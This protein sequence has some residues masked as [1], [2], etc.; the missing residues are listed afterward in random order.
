MEKHFYI[1]EGPEADALVAEVLEREKAT[2]EA[3]EALISEYEAD[4]LIL[5]VWNDG[6]V[7]GLAFNRPTHRPYL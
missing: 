5:S 7:T 2:H 3:R 6:K 4:G 1:G